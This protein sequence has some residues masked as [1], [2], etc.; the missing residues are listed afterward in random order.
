MKLQILN[1][2]LLLFSCLPGI[3]SFSQTGG[4]KQYANIDL[5]LRWQKTESRESIYRKAYRQYVA[6]SIS[7]HRA[8]ILESLKKN[9]AALELEMLNAAFTE[10][11]WQAKDYDKAFCWK[12]K[13][14]V[15]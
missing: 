12:E 5:Y 15:L 1:T 6:D 4:I 7:D 14:H 13:C 9:D 10:A 3:P 2:L 11:F 8:H